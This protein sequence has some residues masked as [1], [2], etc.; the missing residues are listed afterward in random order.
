VWRPKINASEL[1]RDKIFTTTPKDATLI[2]LKIT[3]KL[4]PTMT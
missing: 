4:N 2:D 1:K 3:I